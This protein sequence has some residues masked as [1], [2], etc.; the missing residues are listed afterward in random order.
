MQ[1][2][3]VPCHS[4]PRCF[5]GRSCSNPLKASGFVAYLHRL[6]EG[7][8]GLSSVMFQ[9]AEKCHFCAGGFWKAQLLS[10]SK[11]PSVNML[12]LGFFFSNRK[13][14]KQNPPK[15]LQ[16]HGFK[17]KSNETKQRSLYYWRQKLSQETHDI[18][19]RQL[20]YC[21][22]NTATTTNH[23]WSLEGNAGTYLCLAGYIFHC[24]RVT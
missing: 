24:G 8:G 7:K 15:F 13:G 21:R 16:T 2:C 14:K 6:R 5:V 12:V 17:T 1:N 3:I 19:Q 4:I 10:D 11:I 9:K 23:P 22:G 18:F 20:E